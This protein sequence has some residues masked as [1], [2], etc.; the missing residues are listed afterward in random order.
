[1]NCRLL[2]AVALFGVGLSASPLTLHQ[3]NVGLGNCA[4]IEVDGYHML[5]DAGPANTM[6][7]VYRYLVSQG[8]STVDLLVVTHAHNDHFGGVAGL[9]AS[10]IVFRT[11]VDNDHITAPPLTA[12]ETSAYYHAVGDRRAVITAG[13]WSTLGPA[14]TVR[15]QYVNGVYADGS[16]NNYANENDAAAIIEVRHGRFGHYFAADTT[17]AIE[18]RGGLLCGPV[19]SL[20]AGHHGS[21]DATSQAFLDTIRPRAV[22]IS[23]PANNSSMPGSNALNRMYAAGADVFLTQP[24][25]DT[26]GFVRTNIVLVTDGETSFTVLPSNVYPLPEP[27]LFAVSI[28]ALHA[29]SRRRG[30]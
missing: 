15:C 6:P 26:R 17:T 25:A 30:T 29:F 4:L 12:A 16:T 19:N 23:N 13:W 1:M 20:T 24:P 28:A 3:L 21:S 22:F 10:G 7:S 2:C 14:T 8:V 9:A 27:G 5:A 18:G 11:V